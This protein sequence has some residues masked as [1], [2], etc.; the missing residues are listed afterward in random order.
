MNVSVA[1]HVISRGHV[2]EVLGL[3]AC[4]NTDF[5]I[6]AK[7]VER[8]ESKMHSAGR[9]ESLTLPKNSSDH[10]GARRARER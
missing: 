5:A 4:A 8:E 10:K 1:G 7:G 2:P 6:P 3:Q 9:E